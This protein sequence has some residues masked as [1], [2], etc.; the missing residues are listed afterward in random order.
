MAPEAFDSDDDLGLGQTLR[1]FA[2]GQKVFNRYALQRIL[3]RGGM[4]VVW[5]A[6]DEIL[7]ERVALKFLPEA[8]I[9]D[10]EAI[11]DLKHETKRSRELNHHYIVRIHDFL[12]DELVAGI[13]MEY[14]DGRTLT[15][16]KLKQPAKC[17]NASD[18]MGLVAQLCEAMEY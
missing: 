17:F 6:H 16:L 2:A 18:L 13:S 4:G 14:V 11:E 15:A 1:G 9:S 8:V 5:L 7:Q 10:L 3:G 12:Q